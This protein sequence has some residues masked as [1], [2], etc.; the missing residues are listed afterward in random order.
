M[1]R[2]KYQFA[3]SNPPAI[4][5]P[6]RFVIIKL[7]TITKSLYI[8]LNINICLALC[9]SLDLST[10][11]AC[12][13]CVEKSVSYLGGIDTL[14]NSAGIASLMQTVANIQLTDLNHIMF[15][16]FQ[17]PLLLM[18]KSFPYLKQSKGSVVNISSICK[19]I[20]FSSKY[21]KRN[22]T[23]L[24]SRSPFIGLIS[25]YWIMYLIS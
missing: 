7:I 20:Y 12:E 24:V 11:E 16:N 6:S 17:A 25:L 23:A 13:Q 10:S 9:L 3:N 8:I 14:V 15:V 18:Q 21:D 2:T 5:S 1:V 22:F 19:S 4:S